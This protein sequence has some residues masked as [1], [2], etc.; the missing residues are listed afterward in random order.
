MLLF[1]YGSSGSEADAIDLGRDQPWRI[2]LEYD[3]AVS[4][5]ERRSL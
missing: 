1:R 4:L 5:V 2:G 3:S